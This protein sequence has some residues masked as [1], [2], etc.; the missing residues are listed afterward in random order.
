MA[1]LD[2]DLLVLHAVEVDL[3][4]ARHL[5]EPLPEPLRHRL[6]L[7]VVGAL[8][9]EHVEDRVDVAVL[10]VDVR[11][12]EV[13]RQLGPQIAELLAQLIEEL[14]HLLRRRVVAEH[15]LHRREGGLGVGLHP[16]EIGQLLQ[17]L[18]DPVRDLV[19]HLLCGRTGPDCG[20]DRDLDGKVRVLRPPEPREGERACD[21]EAEDKEQDE[22][23]LM[24]RPLREVE[25]S[26]LVFS[27]RPGP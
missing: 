9:G 22:R 7:R 2:E 12:D 17:L 10:V 11:A 23:G 4:G 14:R 27:E 25:A 21:P 3:D 13:A 15:D 20:H 18:L 24:D 1:E 6:E 19:L 26:H 5:E 8:A 16:V